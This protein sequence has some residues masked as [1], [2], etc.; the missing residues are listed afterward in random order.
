MLHTR[1]TAL[2]FLPA[3]LICHATLAQPVRKCLVIGID[4]LRADALEAAD[5]PRMHFL[6]AHG[7]YARDAQAEDLTFSGPNWSSIL[8]GVHR[9]L[10]N[11]TTNDYSNNHLDQF[12]DFLAYLE[13]HNPDLVTA[14]L[15][16]WDAIFIHQPTG[17]D[18]DIFRN[19]TADGDNLITD[20]AALLLTG[21]HP[22]HSQDPDVLFVYLS[23]VDVAGH[24]F[25]FHPSRPGYLAAIHTADEQVGR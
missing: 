19:Y 23:D 5:A 3:L 4:G 1:C 15:T 21:N 12:P 18:L 20:D 24:T 2:L 22:I 14:R 11:V 13:Q 16:T 25:G 7:C 9:D 8:H 17:A 6:L 10:H